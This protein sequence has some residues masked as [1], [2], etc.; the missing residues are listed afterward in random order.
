MTSANMDNAETKNPAN[1]DTAATNPLNESVAAF[2]SLNSD[3]RLVALASIY[4]EVGSSIQTD[5]GTPSSAVSE[6]VRKVEQIPQQ[7]QAGALRDILTAGRNDQGEV[8]LDPHPSQALAELATG[9]GDNIPTGEYNSLDA[10]SK[11]AFWHQIVQRLGS[12]INFSPSSE[13]T[14]FLNS[15]KSLDDQQRMN[16]LK[17]V[18]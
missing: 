6:L 4:Q 15:F 8:V 9:G 11:L 3:D 10:Q 1:T 18:V 7:E 2:N 13:V 12:R 16:F 5:V 14:E 17:R